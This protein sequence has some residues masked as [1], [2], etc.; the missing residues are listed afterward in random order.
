MNQKEEPVL[1]DPAAKYRLDKF[2][3]VVVD[4]RWPDFEGEKNISITYNGTQSTAFTLAPHE[5]E[6]LIVTLKAA[7][8]L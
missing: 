7:F 4:S 3:I 2:G 1:I 8:K 5:A 6:R